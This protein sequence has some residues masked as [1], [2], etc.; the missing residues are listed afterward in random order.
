MCTVG[1]ISLFL[2]PYL[3]LIFLKFHLIISFDTMVA[4]ERV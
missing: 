1:T 4:L 2:F 3:Y